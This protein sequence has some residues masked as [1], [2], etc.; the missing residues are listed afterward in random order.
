MNQFAYLF[1]RMRATP[2]GDGS[3]LD[4]SMLLYGSGISDSNIH[5]HD[6]LPLVLVGGAAAGIKGGRHLQYPK[7]TPVPTL[8]LSMLDK[9]GVAVESVGDS[10]GRIEHL[11]G[12]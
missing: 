9:V 4:H 10:T 3:L 6:N 2:D 12:V 7:D 11:P 5:L 1:E 8:Y